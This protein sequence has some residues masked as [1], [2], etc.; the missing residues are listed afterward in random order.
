[1]LNTGQEAGFMVREN[2]LSTTCAPAPQL[3]VACTV[4]LNVPIAVGIPEMRPAEFI[5]S[6]DGNKPAIRLKVTVA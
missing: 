4:K 5:F 3:S 1:M 6:P 2:A